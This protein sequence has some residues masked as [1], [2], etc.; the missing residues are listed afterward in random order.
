MLRNPFYAN[1]TSTWPSFY[2]KTTTDSRYKN[3]RPVKLQTISSQR[4]QLRSG[5]VK[6]VAYD[7]RNGGAAA[8]IN[9]I[10]VV[11]SRGRSSLRPTR[12]RIPMAELQFLSSVHPQSGVF[13]ERTRY[14]PSSCMWLRLR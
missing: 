1:P 7:A 2:T 12:L 6:T 4:S 9:R 13:T 11:N 8:P 14:R 3:N 10:V 5:A